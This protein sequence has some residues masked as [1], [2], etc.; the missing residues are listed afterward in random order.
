[1]TAPF[2]AVQCPR[3]GYAD[4]F[5]CRLGLPVTD[6]GVAHRHARPLVAKHAGY[7]RQRDALQNG[8]AGYRVPEVMQAH[9]IDS[10]FLARQ[11]PERQVMR[12]R[13]FGIDMCRE[14]IGALR[15]RLPL[16]DGPCGLL[17]RAL[18]R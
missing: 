10:G 18:G 4:A 7:D 13:L 16:Q 6:M 9:V 14:D 17:F 1:M 12:E 5:R 2:A 15:S 11:T 8:V 3:D